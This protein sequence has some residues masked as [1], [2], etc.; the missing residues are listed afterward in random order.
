MSMN[1]VINQIESLVKSGGYVADKNDIESICSGNV[2]NLYEKTVKTKEEFSGENA[3]E[4]IQQIM[5]KENVSQKELAE[6]MGCARQNVSQILNRGTVNM[7]YDSLY[8]MAKALEYE[9]ILRKTS[10]NVFL[11]SKMIDKYVNTK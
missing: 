11:R 5:E 1:E 6:R 8:R 3:A 9:I 4:V 7:R 10:K 2:P